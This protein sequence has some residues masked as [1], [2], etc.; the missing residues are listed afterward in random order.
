MWS[1]DSDERFRT[2]V[3]QIRRVSQLLILT[4][5]R[6]RKV[7]ALIIDEVSMLSGELFDGIEEEICKIREKTHPN[8]P[9]GGIQLIMS[10]VKLSI[11]SPK[12]LLST[13]SCL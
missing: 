2:N 3:G 13:T 1:S 7:S 8:E 5:D 6:L 10:G 4:V 11:R 12:G 9:F